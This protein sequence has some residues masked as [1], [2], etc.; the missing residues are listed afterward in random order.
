MDPGDTIYETLKSKKKRGQAAKYVNHQVMCQ[1]Y[2]GN[3]KPDRFITQ[4]VKSHVQLLKNEMIVG[5]SI[6][7]VLHVTSNMVHTSSVTF[8]NRLWKTI[9]RYNIFFKTK[10]DG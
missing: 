1:T 9:H 5:K 7:N 6:S 8:A 10:E 3:L 2:S 4:E